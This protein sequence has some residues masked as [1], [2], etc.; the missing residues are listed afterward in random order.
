MLVGIDTTVLKDFFLKLLLLKLK[1]IQ[2]NLDLVFFPYIKH[3]KS[4]KGLLFYIF[5]EN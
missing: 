2:T 3:S 5:E 1:M 4:M